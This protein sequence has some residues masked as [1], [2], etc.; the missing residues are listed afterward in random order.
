MAVW[1]GTCVLSLPKYGSHSAWREL[2]VG[3]THPWPCI[4]QPEQGLGAPNG[5][6]HWP[7]SV[8]VRGGK[9]DLF[10]DLWWPRV[11]HQTTLDQTRKARTKGVPKKPWNGF[12]WVGKTMC[13]ADFQTRRNTEHSVANTYNLLYC[14]LDLCPIKWTVSL[15]MC[16]REKPQTRRV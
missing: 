10:D 1:E 16:K 15:L 12:V 2:R 5:V 8:S 4:C 6:E 3:L 9:M 13:V 11:S 14:F 7:H